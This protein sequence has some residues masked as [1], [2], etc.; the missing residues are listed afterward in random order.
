MTVGKASNMFNIA[1]NK[2]LNASTDG[3]TYG[4]RWGCI[5]PN[6]NKIIVLKKMVDKNVGTE[7]QG[8]DA[9]LVSTSSSFSYQGVNLLNPLYS[10][11]QLSKR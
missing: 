9:A 1:M 2:V 5:T 6:A 8:H 11:A 10:P 3:V 7:K 4:L